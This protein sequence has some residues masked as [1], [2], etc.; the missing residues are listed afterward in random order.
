MMNPELR[1]NVKYDSLEDTKI[2]ILC[3]GESIRWKNY[4]NIPKQLAVVNGESL[5][6]RMVRL[7]NQRGYYD[8]DI[9][10]HNEQL[11][12]DSCGFF[13]PS[14]KRWIVETLFASQ[15]LWKEKTIV[16]LGDVFFTQ[17]AINT[18]INIKH[19]IHIYARSGASKYTQSHW[20]EIFALSFTKHDWHKVTTHAELTCHDAEAGGRGKLWEFYRSLAGFPLDQHMVEN[21]IFIP[22]NDLTD[23]IDSPYEYEYFKNALSVILQKKD[24]TLNHPTKYLTMI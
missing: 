4:L 10:S 21:S 18:I 1:F 15:P 24:K 12:M 23:D 14:K 16:L 13:K 20:G 2:I 22:I 6:Q 17:H 11:K 9:V 19:G 7:L 8:I 3:A 5:I